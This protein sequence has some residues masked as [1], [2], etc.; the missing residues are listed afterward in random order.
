MLVK[1]LRQMAKTLPL[2]K[3]SSEET[4]N[5]EFFS[6]TYNQWW[7]CFHGAFLWGRGKRINAQSK[8]Y[9]SICN[10]SKFG[11]R[12]G[13]VRLGIDSAKWIWQSYER[14]PCVPGYRWASATHCGKTRNK[15]IHLTWKHSNKQKIG[16]WDF[17][18][19]NLIRQAN[20][21]HILPLH[22][23]CFPP[24]SQYCLVCSLYSTA[25]CLHRDAALQLQEIMDHPSFLCRIAPII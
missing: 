14:S 15:N 7:G 12:G 8:G 23:I 16:S 1:E 24:V 20:Y 19:P 5:G 3:V 17:W 18:S 13:Q 6:L 22:L 10:H 25:W 2:P 21:P 9:K 11:S 4:N